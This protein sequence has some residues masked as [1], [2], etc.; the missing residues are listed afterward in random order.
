MSRRIVVLDRGVVL[1]VGVG[2]VAAGL[3]GLDWRYAW[4]LDRPDRLDTT[5]AADVVSSSWWPWAAA[6]AGVVLG[7]LGLWWLLAHLRRPGPAS[8][9]LADSDA[10]GLL[11]ADLRSVASAC[12]DRFAA[13]APVVAMRGS[14]RSVGP[15]TVVLL[16]GQ[17]DAYADPAAVT[18]AV[19]Q[20]T[21]DL[22]AAF[23]GE[24]LTCRV[25]LD[26]PRRSRTGR[27]ARVR[28]R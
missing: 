5:T 10:T 28:V 7:L 17:V 24:G 22:A 4:F 3:V 23:P 1:L 16:N 11:E 9:R 6:G 2:L 13:Q 12:A 14:T 21:A 8:R 15:R 20:C 27:T 19:A 26:A 25:V 18:D